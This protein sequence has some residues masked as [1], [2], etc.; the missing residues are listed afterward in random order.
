[1]NHQSNNLLSPARRF[2]V[3]RRRSS[4][5]MTMAEQ[6]RLP[7]PQA[8]HPTARAF[9][10]ALDSSSSNKKQSASLKRRSQSLGWRNRYSQE[11]FFPITIGHTTSFSVLQ[12]QRGEIEG[13]YGTGATVWP[14]AVVLVKYLEKNPELVEK[15]KVVDLGSGT[16]VTSVAA[17]VLGASHVICTDG[18][19][20]VVKLAFSN[21]NHSAEEIRDSKKACDENNSC[22]VIQNCPVVCQKLWWGDGIVADGDCDVVIVADCVLPKLYPIAPL[23]QAIDEHLSKSD[24]VAILSYEHRYYH[25][26]DPRDKFRELAHAR[27]LQVD[28]IPAENLNP[29][30]CLDDIEIW[31]VRRSE[32]TS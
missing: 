12:V 10:D 16:G 23:V 8:A 22:A 1:M 27:G 6:E 30:Y 4:L 20:N 21:V 15:K 11:N 31:H 32:V 13:T 25:Q 24:S 2:F 9:F 7:L 28:L 14:A 19:V 5:K 26:Y 3:A 17:A 29:V 18:E